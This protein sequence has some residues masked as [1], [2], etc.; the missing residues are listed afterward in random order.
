MLIYAPLL[1]GQA[2][3]IAETTQ[4]EQQAH[5]DYTD[6]LIVKLRNHAAGA[7]QALMSE[8]QVRALSTVAGVPLSGL[9]PMSGSAYVLRLPSRM[10][11]AAATAIAQRLG[12]DPNVLYA[13]PDRI[14]HPMLVP[15]DSLYASQ[16]HY[17]EP[18]TELGGAN[19]PA[20]WDITTGSA[21][22]I[23]AVIDTGIL[24]VHADLAGR[25]VSGHD[26]IS[27]A[28]VAN[29][30]DGRDPN[31]TD[32]G[33]WIT[34]AESTEPGGLFEGCPV[35]ASSWHGTHVAGTI[36]ASSN[37]SLG[38]A[39]INWASRILPVRVLGKCGGFLSDT[40]DG[41]RWAAGL[42]VPGVPAN[43]NPAHVLNL[44]LGGSGSCGITEQDAINEIVAAGKVVVAA[45][46]NQNGDAANVSPANCNGVITVAATTR[47]G[48]KA[49]YSNFGTVVE[50]SAPGGAQ[51]FA[52][53]PNGV[54]STLNSGTTIPAADDYKFYQGTSM[55]AAHV[56]GIVSLMLSANPE[57]PLSDVLTNIQNAARAFPDA[58]C[59]ASTCG[60]GIIDAAAAVGLGSR[61]LKNSASDVNF[62]DTLVSTTTPAQSV[63][64]TNTNTGSTSLNINS[65]SIAGSDATDFAVTSDTCTGA[66]LPPGD[67]CSISVAF[68]PS[69]TGTRT[70]SLSVL[71]DASNSPNS[72]AL[73]GTG[74]APVA[75]IAPASISFPTTAV[76]STAPARSVTLT[77]TGTGPLIV[78]VV[79]ITGEN[80]A[81][82]AI[83]ADS[84][85]NQTIA[86]GA[87][88]SISVTYTPGAPGPRSANLN[89][90]SNA[91]GSPHSVGL[92]GTDVSP[93][94]GNGGCYIVTAAFG[95]P[96]AAEV[97]VLRAFRDR[98]LL[99]HAPGR[100]LVA[101]YYR[102]SPPLAALVR[103]H[104]PL[105]AATRGLLWPVVWWA[106]LALV[107]PV[108]ALTLGVGTLASGPLLLYI[109]LRARR[110]RIARR[111]WR[112]TR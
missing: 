101:A 45:A 17:K 81:D 85:S 100:L 95:S 2:H 84:C 98:M 65:A 107:S 9:R 78:G 48:S 21:D 79:S 12:A 8:A 42:P 61:I 96:L 71:S 76:G 40:V 14:M 23:V 102:M 57:L 27:V 83:S 51:T 110:T 108:L 64:L 16:W 53:D 93:S 58:T 82:F 26:F 37:N 41:A 103:E 99:I 89:L 39:G 59:A 11:V 92:S 67:A 91:G 54:L 111:T 72:V 50:I 46:G 74:T 10:A 7:Q 55:A 62:V 34:S 77:N 31:P 56:A 1:M 97:Q 20:A 28:P 88:C 29:D 90:P 104:E 30:G 73:S 24:L 87:N 68:T 43:A 80:P 5:T 15:S 18:A 49:P 106:H 4:F 25:T 44:S 63:T 3:G 60:A 70:A 86:P 47:S 109:S 52:S 112:T 105:Q 6:R 75:S 33:D 94:G 35:S 38:A 32:P 19:L 22:I 13:E 69:A 36:G 66:M